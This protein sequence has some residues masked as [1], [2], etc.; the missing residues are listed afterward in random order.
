MVGALPRLRTVWS[1]SPTQR[2]P[3][4]SGV[5]SRR[6]SELGSRDSPSCMRRSPNEDRALLR[7]LPCRALAEDLVAEQPPGASSTGD[8]AEDEQWSRIFP[9]EGSVIRLV[10][11][12]LSEQHDRVRR[13]ANVHFTRRVVGVKLDLSQG[14]N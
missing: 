14:W 11:S 2:A 8:Q 7:R 5:G 9:T 1:P 6:A 3:T 4:S 13:S 10:G 12:I